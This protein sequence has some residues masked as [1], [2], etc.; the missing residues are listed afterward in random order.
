MRIFLR[1]LL[2]PLISLFI[3][4]GCDNP[5]LVGLDDQQFENGRLVDTFTVL[6]GTV[7]VGRT[8][9]DNNVL[10]RDYS[11]YLLS[12]ISYRVAGYFN[13]PVFGSTDARSFTQVFS[14]G[15]HFGDNPVLDSAVLILR[16]PSL[17]YKGLYGDTLSHVN[18][19]VEELTEDLVDTAK[20]YSDQ[21]FSTG[22]VLGTHTFR[23]N[24]RDS[25]MLQAFVKDGPDS[26]VKAPPQ[27]RIPL[28]KAYLTSRLLDIDTAILNDQEQFLEYFKGISIRM[29]PGTLS[30]NGALISFN[31]TSENM[32]ELRL[33]YRTNDNADTLSKSFPMNSSATQ[34]SYFGHNYTN[35]PVADALS[36]QPGEDLLYI[37]SL[38]GVQARLR[39][40]YLKDLTGDGHISVNKA[41]LIL[42]LA[43]G[44]D[45]DYHPVPQL[46][47]HLGT[48]TAGSFVRHVTDTYANTAATSLFNGFYQKET[49]SYRFNITRHIQSVLNGEIEQDSLFVGV[50]STAYDQ[51]GRVIGSINGVNQPSRVVV[52]G[53]GHPDFRARLKIV[54]SE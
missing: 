3:L 25:I 4:Q 37:Q 22:Q 54:Y 38:Q 53:G 18:I 40:P 46:F 19:V 20:Y 43:P 11:G 23:V 39:F 2:L 31:M 1:G 12:P 36:G 16:Y 13:D 6:S 9:T 35:T 24:R 45:A 5:G 32:S 29:D 42:E 26:L 15:G 44:S 21:L 49:H 14:T 34:A 17:S 30:S 8:R 10:I 28:D 33:Y 47:A 41:E 52:G 48:D 50:L 51:S 7:P 27:L